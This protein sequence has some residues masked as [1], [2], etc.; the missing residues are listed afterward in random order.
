MRELIGVEEAR[1]L[2]LGA[3]AVLPAE[4]VGLDEALGRTLAAPVV[5]GGP[6]PAFASSAMDGFA[7]RTA[8][9]ASLPITLPVAAEVAAGAVPRRPGRAG[10]GGGG[11]T[12]G[13]APRGGR[14]A[15]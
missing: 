11:Q 9:L 12:G 2:V 4:P 3:A 1:R 7:V 5:S 14:A 13:A 15:V 6:V 10:T 8:D